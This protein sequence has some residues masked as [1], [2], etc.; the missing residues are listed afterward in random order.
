VKFLL[1]KRGSKV[2]V[3]RKPIQESDTGYGSG[4]IW[5]KR[6]LKASRSLVRITKE[7]AEYE[8]KGIGNKPRGGRGYKMPKGEQR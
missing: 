1:V 6:D 8:E 4:K 5:G 2:G 3:S 7:K